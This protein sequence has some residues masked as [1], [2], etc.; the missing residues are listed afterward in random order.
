MKRASDD[1]VANT[2]SPTT[3]VGRSKNISSMVMARIVH[4]GPERHVK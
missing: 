1:T 2:V 3:L 4:A